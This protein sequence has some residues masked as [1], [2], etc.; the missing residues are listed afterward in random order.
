MFKLNKKCIQDKTIHLENSKKIIWNLP[1]TK[2]DAY[3]DLQY[4]GIKA[5]PNLYSQ[6]KTYPLTFLPS[7]IEDS[8]KCRG[9]EVSEIPSLLY[10]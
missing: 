8:L 10:V 6:E 3:H 1:I 2:V 5:R 9:L 7:I 4:K